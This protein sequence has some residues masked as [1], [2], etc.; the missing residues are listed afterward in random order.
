M[1][2]RESVSEGIEKRESR[3]PQ[4]TLHLGPPRIIRFSRLRKSLDD[5]PA[6]LKR[7]PRRIRIPQIDHPRQRIRL[8][9]ARHKLHLMK[10]RHPLRVLLL[11]IAHAHTGLPPALP[12]PHHRHL[13]PRAHVRRE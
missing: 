11:P 7:D 5:P 6:I 13:E 3:T 12:V 8:R 1:R 9:H 2:E 10:C 4:R